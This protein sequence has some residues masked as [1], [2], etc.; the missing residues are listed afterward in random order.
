MKKIKYLTAYLLMTTLLLIAIVGC[1]NPKGQEENINQEE[2]LATEEPVTTEVPAVPTEG[3]SFDSERKEFEI[4]RNFL[5]YSLSEEDIADFEAQLLLCEQMF[6]DGVPYSDMEVAV[7][8][9]EELERGLQYQAAIAKVLY[10]CN[11]Q[12]EEAID[13][14]LFSAEVVSEIKAEKL[15]FL[16]KLYDSGKYDRYFDA[17]TDAMRKH[18]EAYSGETAELE[19]HNE[20]LLA[21]FYALQEEEV[22]EKIDCLY[23]EFVNN[24]NELATK[25]GFE[26]YYE[27]ASSFLYGRDY[28]KEER[29][30]FRKYVK[31][32][33]VP[34]YHAS[35]ERYKEEESGI[36]EE[37]KNFIRALLYDAYDSL[38]TDYVNAY[39][40]TLPESCKT[41][42]LRMF[43]EEAYV[44]PDNENALE[45]AYTTYIGAPFCYYGP[46]RQ[47]A[48]TFVHEIGH[49]YGSFNSGTSYALA[50]TRSQGNELLF[51]T[52]L[53]RVLEP[54]EYEALRTYKLFEYIDIILM[55]TIMD[56]FEETIYSLPDRREYTVEDFDNIMYEIVE[57]YGLAED[58][59]TCEYAEE[60]W[61][62]VGISYPIYYLNYGVSAMAA[63]NLYG[64]SREDYD[65]ALEA[66]RIIQEEAVTDKDFVGTLE[67]AGVDS[68]FDEEAYIKLQG[69]IE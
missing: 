18:Y 10:N 24:S 23:S 19:F 54:K 30:Q 39:L 51:L 6:A 38:E 22:E 25:Y 53:G 9:M 1:G 66:Y 60:L 48:F 15:C 17:A 16:V 62:N 42:M 21:D 12:D 36:S 68:V 55:A 61:R 33:I 14:Y 7:Q 11:M 35:Y 58:E 34:L 47:D 67:K 27:Y 45:G 32:Y 28:G 8:T 59:K 4:E 29:E 52:Y 46:H 5:Q 57:S 26:S 3:P 56:E 2:P 43:E 63:L 13:N 20:E 44:R 40:Q 41:G 50:E 64:L 31:K 37:E 69:L 65:A 49:Y